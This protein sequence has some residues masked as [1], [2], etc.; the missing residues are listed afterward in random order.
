MHTIATYF[1]LIKEEV[2]K[3]WILENT[4]FEKIFQTEKLENQSELRP[5]RSIVLM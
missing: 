5:K 2:S 4:M 1:L 3:N